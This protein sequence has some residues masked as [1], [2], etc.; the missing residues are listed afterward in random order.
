MQKVVGMQK[1]TFTGV[2]LPK[3][4]SLT[5]PEIEVHHGPHDFGFP[6]VMT[7]QIQRSIIDVVF[8]LQHFQNTW[9][10]TLYLRASNLARACVDVVGF[11]T[12]QGLIVHLETAVSPG[13]NI[14]EL[15]T[16]NPVVIGLCTAYKSPTITNHDHEELATVLSLV[17]AEPELWGSMFDLSNALSSYH[18]AP[19]NCGRVLDSLRR[20]VAPSVEPKNGWPILQSVVNADRP[21]MSFVSTNSTASRH[22]ERNPGLPESVLD[23][24][25]R[26][27]WTITNRFIEYR[28]RG[29]SK[30][31]LAEF[32]MLIG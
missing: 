18:D 32:P 17:V 9:L 12:G 4:L 30:L 8:Y 16:W 20:A 3:R 14:L 21:Y 2:V 15:V 19:T 10:P 26:R 5:V 29:S 27:T 23:E 13:G 22:G 7:V 11:A 24:M 31:D 6:L 28:K 25:M 1:V